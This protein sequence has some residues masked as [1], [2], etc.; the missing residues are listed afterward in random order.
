MKHNKKK[1]ERKRGM[2]LTPNNNRE[3]QP[4]NTRTPKEAMTL[5]QKRQERGKSKTKNPKLMKAKSDLVRSLK[6][7]G[8][9]KCD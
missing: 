1:G 9:F 2:D 7:R 4:S 3:E 5:S 8:Y 6:Q